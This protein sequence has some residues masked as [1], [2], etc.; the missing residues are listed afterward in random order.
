MSDEGICLVSSDGRLKVC[1]RY[2]DDRYV[3][4]IS[5]DGI[6]AAASLDGDSDQD[7]PPSPPLQQLSLENLDGRDVILGVGAAGKSH[8][9]LA[10][11]PTPEAEGVSGLHFEWACRTTQS[12][13][14]LMASYTDVSSGLQIVAQSSAAATEK[15]S[16]IIFRPNAGQA[17]PTFQWAYRVTV[18]SQSA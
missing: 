16:G 9:S 11:E 14:D 15:E 1:F 7:W 10:V 8:F 12:D 6:R 2:Q 3:H 18:Q 4:E 13:P 17:C 5:V